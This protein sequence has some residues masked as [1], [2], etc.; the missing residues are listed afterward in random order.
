VL[1][2]LIG[3]NWLTAHDD[4]G[5]RRLDDPEDF[6]RIEIA[7]ALQRK[8]PVIPI[9]LDDTKVPKKD[10]LPDDLKE[11]AD[12]HG[13]DVRDNAFHSDIDRL[14]QTLEEILRPRSL[15]SLSDLH[16]ADFWNDCSE[17]AKGR[18]FGRKQRAVFLTVV[19]P[20]G[21]AKDSV[22]EYL[23]LSSDGVAVPEVCLELSHL[24]KKSAR[25]RL[26]VET[27]LDIDL[28]NEPKNTSNCLSCKNL[29][30]LGTPDIN[31]ITRRVI[32]KNDGF[33]KNKVQ[34]GFVAP[35]STDIIDS[36][37]RAHNG[38]N[39]PGYGLLGMYGNPWT[40]PED[41]RPNNRRVA[42]VCGGCGAQGT[43]A[44]TELLLRMICEKGAATNNSKN[45]QLAVRLVEGTGKDYHE[46]VHLP[47]ARQPQ[48]EMGNIEEF[49]VHE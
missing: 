1:L 3:P 11:L 22:A 31:E 19:L 25:L 46:S 24:I 37:G 35:I 23:A 10:Q 40:V 45:A 41:G 36:E 29:L 9:L 39:K 27:V 14:I 20:T 18:K 47:R 28:L 42:L 26:K 5:N 43:I 48:V 12:L 17:K 6:V 13:L 38:K 44:A 15:T 16:S 30:L 7:I 33:A 2:A 49:K 8:I 4:D 32:E 34:P 21:R